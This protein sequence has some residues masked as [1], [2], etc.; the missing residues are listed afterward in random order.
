MSE[1]IHP[2]LTKKQIIK[3]T[4]IAIF[5][6]ALL[7]ICAVL[8]AEYGIDPTGAGKAFGFK[9]LYISP[10]SVG[11]TIVMSN[12]FPLIRREE[13]GSGPQVKRPVEAD[14]PAPL[15]QYEERE[16]SV[17]VIIPAGKGK[18]YKILMLKYARATYE[19]KTDKG[20]LYF[21]CHGEVK[22]AQETE[23]EYFE[24]YAVGYSNN[25][26]GTLLAPYEGTHGWY[27]RNKSQSDIV[28][29]IRMKGQYI[30][31]TASKE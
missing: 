7:L 9:K 5:T 23:D 27:F 12:S 8:P 20:V 19:W 22:Q 2:I 4:V 13:A 29:T 18:E 24:S 31:Q 6:G 26:V 15:K 30:L 25:I 17:Q 16:D 21:D 28:V 1:M 10:D 3:A 11:S 14:N